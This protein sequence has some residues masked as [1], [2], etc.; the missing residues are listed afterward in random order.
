[1]ANHGANPDVV[2]LL[3]DFSQRMDSLA[4]QG[5]SLSGTNTS[6]INAS[7]HGVDATSNSYP[8]NETIP[9]VTGH[10]THV[11]TRMD[12]IHKHKQVIANLCGVSL[13]SCAGIEEFVKS[14]QEGTN[15]VWLELSSGVRDVLTDTVCDLWKEIESTN[16]TE[17]SIGITAMDTTNPNDTRKVIEPTQDSSIVH[18]VTINSNYPIVQSV[19]IN[20]KSTSYACVAGASAKKQPTV[21]FNFRPLVADP[22]FVGL[23]ISIPCRV[24]QKVSIRFE[25]TLYGNFIG[26]RFSF[27][28]VEYY[29]R[30]N[31]GKHRL[32][33]IMMN[34]KGFFF[35]F[36]SRAGL[37]ALL[38]GGIWMIRKTPIILKKWSMGTNLLKEELTRIPIW[39]KLHD[40]PIQVFEEVNSEAN[41][42]DVVTI[43]VPS[44]TRDDYTKETICFEYEWR[45]PRCDTCKIFG[46][47]HDQCSKKVVCHPI[48]TT[49]N[50]VTPTIMKTNDG[51]QTVG[52]KKK[53]NIG[54]SK[55]TNGGQFVG[56]L[57]KQTVTYEPKAPTSAPKKGTN[58]LGTAANSSSKLKNASMSP[59]TDNITLQIRSLL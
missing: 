53:K 40:V 19:D 31:W 51:F 7:T 23:N 10:V 43:G 26:K 32:T 34:N 37:E 22:I 17:G 6:N 24:V 59:N 11:E 46:H 50:V 52:K 57:V 25:H 2:E 38:E 35:K 39:V 29:A 27:S 56:P 48:A 9:N 45:P 28:V 13:N 12:C 44:L 54:K 1:M 42:V 36:D 55:S 18:D 21:C 14:I 33:I 5:A 47:I 58:T 4:G 30:N 3:R 16:A 20:T 49:S 15:E 8:G 41:L